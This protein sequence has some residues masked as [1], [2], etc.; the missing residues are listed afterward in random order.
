MKALSLHLLGFLL[1]ASCAGTPSDPSND[2]ELPGAS[3]IRGSRVRTLLPPD[4]I[5]SIDDPRFVPA[6]SADFMRDDEPVIGVV[7]DLSGSTYRSYHENPAAIGVRGTV[8]PD[9]RLPGKTLV[10]GIEI[11]EIGYAM[12]LEAAESARLTNTEAGGILLLIA[13]RDRAVRVYDRRIDGRALSFEHA[14]EDPLALV[15]DRETGS[16]WNATSGLAVEGPL[17]G[18]ALQP[19][20]VRI[21][22]WGVWAQFH[23]ESEI[24]RP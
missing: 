22:Y 16:T 12:T 15:R 20:P 19:L 1:A 18:R 2:G 4:A 7:V 13:A 9:R 3:W 21:V 5:P 6:A 11:A 14:G 17:E 10:L 8:N 23:R 24:L